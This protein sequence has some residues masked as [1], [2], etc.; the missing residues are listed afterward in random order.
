MLPSST[1]MR[2]AGDSSE[3][4]ILLCQNKLHRVQVDC[5][6]HIYSHNDLK[7]HLNHSCSLNKCA[8]RRFSVGL[9]PTFVT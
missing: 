1:L 6:L 2:E 8:L 9:G 3:T 7:S 4:L 5:N